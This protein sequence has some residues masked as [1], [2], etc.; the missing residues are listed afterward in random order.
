MTVAD[1]GSGPEASAR[2]AR[3]Q[4][5]DQKV[6]HD[7]VLILGHHADDQVETVLYRLLRGSGVKGLAGMPAERPLLHGRVQRPLLAVSQHTLRCY[8]QEHSLQWIED[9]SNQCID[10][11]RNYLRHEVIPAL[12]TRWPDLPASVGR[13]ARY[14]TEA[15][16]LSADLAEL[17]LARIDRQPARV[18]CSVSI[19]LLRSLPDYRQRNVLRYWRVSGRSI[20]S[21]DPV[22]PGHRVLDTVFAEVIGA[23]ADAQPVVRWPGGEWRRFRGRLYCLPTDWQEPKTGA[24]M[25]M[26]PWP[27]DADTPETTFPLPN[28]GQL[29]AIRRAGKG[30]SIPPGATV[31]VSFRSGGE[32][33]KPVGRSASTTL[34]KLFQEYHLE[35][36]LRAGVPL[37]Y[38]D[39]QLAAVGDLWVCEGHQ[40]LGVKQQG[41]RLQWSV[42]KDAHA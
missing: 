14:S 3:Y 29:S 39:D 20:T 41:Y 40:V 7:E 31:S 8:A 30:L 19:D 12:L 21:E 16:R 33:C 25:T 28:G 9:E 1:D 34:K 5:F 32:R 11:D 2:A 27:V 24:Q 15:D 4:V 22:F 23:R 35:P 6:A 10:Y 42:V 17:D 36:W 38:L 13:S 26:L 37:I 18:G